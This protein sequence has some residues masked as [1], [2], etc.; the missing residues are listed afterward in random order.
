MLP[1]SIKDDLNGLAKWLREAEMIQ[2]GDKAWQ[3][4][5]SGQLDRLRSLLEKLNLYER[6]RHAPAIDDDATDNHQ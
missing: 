4:T 3:C 2:V 6:V 5:D 1:E